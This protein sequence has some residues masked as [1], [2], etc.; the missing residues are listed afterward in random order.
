MM[1]ISRCSLV[2]NRRRSLAPDQ[3]GGLAV[4]GRGVSRP[5]SVVVA[6]FVAMVV[7]SAIAVVVLRAIG[8]DLGPLK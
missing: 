7:L 5:T 8:S 6:I 4:A 2:Q 1:N 3:P